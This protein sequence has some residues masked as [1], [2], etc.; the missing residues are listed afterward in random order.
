MSQDV[1]YQVSSYQ[2]NPPGSKSADSTNQ[3]DKVEVSLRTKFKTAG[4]AAANH[5]KERLEQQ[6]ASG[7]SPSG[8]PTQ[9]FASDRWAQ[10]G[11]N[12]KMTA[13]K[14]KR[15]RE[16]T[17]EKLFSRVVVNAIT[18]DVWSPPPGNSISGKVVPGFLVKHKHRRKCSLELH[19]VTPMK[20]LETSVRHEN[21]QMNRSHPYYES[22]VRILVPENK[23]LSRKVKYD[24]LKDMANNNTSMDTF[25][26]VQQIRYDQTDFNHDDDATVNT[27]SST[28]SSATT[29]YPL[30]EDHG[31]R[32][33]GGWKPR[34]SLPM[35]GI[36]IRAQNKKTVTIL[37]SLNDFKQERDLIFDTTE[38]ASSFIKEVEK[39]QRLE[40]DR[41]DER[42]RLSLGR[43]ITLPKFEKL[44]LLFEIVSAYNIPIGDLKSC[45]PYVSVFMG[46]QEVHRTDIR[47]NTLNPIW[48]LGTGSLFLLQVESRRFFVEDGLKFV[49]KDYDRGNKDDVLGICTVGPKTIYTAN[50]ERMEFNLTPAKKVDG[51]EPNLST[52]VLRCRRATAHDLKFMTDFAKNKSKTGVVSY[53]A[54]EADSNVL[55]TLTTKVKK[56]DSNGETLYKARPFPDPN[57]PAIETEWLSK[58]ALQKAVLEP[59]RQW[60]EL[61][62]GDLGKIYLEILG[63]DGLPNMDTGA[64]LGN[65]TD[66]FVACVFEDVYGRTDVIN[67]CLSPRWTS[68]SSRAFILRIAHPSSVLNLGIFDYD[69]GGVDNHD[70]IGR[71]SVDLTNFRSATE[72]VLSYNFCRSARISE[73][74]SVGKLMI[75]LRMEVEDER[76]LAMAALYPPPP[77]YVNTKS[78]KD[79]YVIKKT[80]FGSVNEDR[81]SVSTLKSYV[82]ELY[83]LQHVL[84]H[85]EDG[86]A[87]L[88]LWRGQMEV[89]IPYLDVEINVPIH[90]IC[91]FIL[92]TFLV[93]H[94]TLIP[95]FC[96][97]TL[98]WLLL[99]IGGWRQSS[100]NVWKRTHSY[101]Q[102]FRMIAFGDDNAEPHKIK[103]FENYEEAKKEA[104]DWV[105]RIEESEKDAALLAEEANQI[106]VERQ[107]ELM[108]VGDIDTA[109]KANQSG[110]SPNPVRAALYPIQIML[111]ILVR[112]IRIISNILS[113]QEAYISFWVTT[114][115]LGLAIVSLFVPWLW[116][117]KWGARIFAW[118]VFGPWMKLVDIYYVSLIA[119]ETE[120]E[121]EHRKRQEKLAQK[122]QNTE[123]AKQAQIKRENTAKLKSMKEYL[124]GKLS[125]RVPI[126]KQDRYQDIPLAESFATPYREKN[127]SLAELAIKEAGYHKTRVPGQT[128]VG[129]MIPYVKEES[130][131]QAPVGK[132]TLH[133]EKLS[134]NAP[135]SKV[136]IVTNSRKIM[137]AFGMAI[138]ITYYGTT[139]IVEML[140]H[141]DEWLT[142]VMAS[143]SNGE[144]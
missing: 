94:P 69:S 82:D 46:H 120:E 1:E 52:L 47:H 60:I 21:E 126:L 143:A 114:C 93:E 104:E 110:I 10:V 18:W 39:Q 134:R 63:C 2:V 116:C 127:F 70:L 13:L 54:P 61:G 65:K 133:P 38:D 79:F 14:A 78:K 53:S 30:I 86:L 112:G 129:D 43:Q 125:I 84:F 137:M 34:Y 68:W 87:T 103:P 26:S 106:E 77:I 92:S 72:Y 42:L 9:D 108:E 138:G 51:D 141:V 83:D 62:E 90:S 95:S 107:R 33:Y 91:A 24:A 44:D 45:D 117:L 71:V 22:I 4:T 144:L 23:E 40:N 80:C 5:A 16:Q 58:E 73:R 66:A 101:S 102:I 15:E 36:Y 109:T 49:I 50:G 97:G 8:E 139:L 7:A 123:I 105:K 89:T 25:T 142:S 118:T 81:Y 56:T 113:W 27:V 76:K 74:K 55:K 41:Q 140:T 96:F 136:G 37:I 17:N 88:L 3:E 48:T 19:R 130:F 57:R 29:K 122:L 132:A 100:E 11:Y 115:S 131:T 12:A 20:D 135:G 99:A 85:I 31:G 128:L 121:R 59:S 32:E 119:P 67:D 75:R 35:Q 64:L 111:G 6:K 28:S 98:A 124:F